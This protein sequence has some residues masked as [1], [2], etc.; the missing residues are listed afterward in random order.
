MRKLLFLICFA[1]LFAGCKGANEGNTKGVD[2]RDNNVEE[3]SKSF[4]FGK[5]VDLTEVIQAYELYQKGNTREQDSILYSFV[6]EEVREDEITLFEDNSFVIQ[7][8]EYKDSKVPYLAAAEDF[9]NS[10]SFLFNIWSNFELWYRGKTADEMLSDKEIV[11]SIRAL[12]VNYIMDT[13]YK[14]AAQTYRDSIL[15]YMAMGLD[16]WDKAHNAWNVRYTYRDVID[17]KACQYYDNKDEFQK[18]YDRILEF[19][20][21]MGDD[22]FNKYLNKDDEEQLNVILHELNTCENFDEQCSLWRRWANCK[23]SQNEDAW[24]VA[25]GNKLMESGKYNPILNRIWMTWRTLCQ[26]CYCGLSKDSVIPNPFYNQ[27]RRMCYYTC[28]KWIE[29]HPD[30]VFAMNCASSLAGLHN[31]IRTGDYPGGNGALYDASII[32]PD[33]YGFENKE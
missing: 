26:F 18:Q 13:E 24:L 16:K 12:D 8:P 28:L 20:E 1:I 33:R 21:G 11:Q 25:V 7:L 22:K 9:Y 6:N 3:L 23:K 31:L 14:K 30:D 15:I 5:P 17:K 32:I 2:A 27:Y 10:C 4:E 19:A 29:K